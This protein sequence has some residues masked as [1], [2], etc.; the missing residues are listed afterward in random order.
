MSDDVDSDR[1][2]LIFSAGFALGTLMRVRGL[3][4]ANAVD[5]AYEATSEAIVLMNKLIDR[6]GGWK[7]KVGERD[8]A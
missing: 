5:Q 8:G 4:A 3:L 7:A 6:D 2:W 1:Q